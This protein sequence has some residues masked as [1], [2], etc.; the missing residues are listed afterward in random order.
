MTRAVFAG[1]AATF[2]A[3]QAVR[4]TDIFGVQPAALDQPRINAYITRTPGGAP[5]AADLGGGFE[6]F[7]IQ[8]FFDTGASGIL[9]SNNTADLLGIQRSTFNGQDVVFSDVG[10]A[11]TDDFNVSELL[12]ISLARFHPDADVDNP[13][14][15]AEYNQTFGQV[16]TQIGPIGV[17]PDPVLGDLDVFG[18]PLM[19]GKVVVMDPKPV[20]TF[21]DTMRTYV[22]NPGTP[23]NSAAA[24][25]DPGIPDMSYAANA[26]NRN[27][28]FSKADFSP[29]T[30]VS[31][32][33]ANGPT[34]TGNPF[35]GPDPTPGHT[36]GPSDPDPVTIGFGG[37][38]TTGSFLLDTGAAASMIS[39][40]KASQLGV[41]YDPSAGMGS[42]DPTLIYNGSPISNQFDLTIGGIGG[43]IKVAGFF[44]D[45]MVLPTVE[46]ESDS[47]LNLNFVGAPVLVADITVAEP[48]GTGSLTLDGIFGMNFLVASAYVTEAEPFP[49][50]DALTPSAFDWAVYDD[51]GSTLGVRIADG[52]TVS[53]LTWVGWA[54]NTW[55]IGNTASWGFL[56]TYQDGNA[57]A[58]TDLIY[59]N[60]SDTI[61]IAQ[62]VAPSNVVFENNTEEQDGVHYTLQGAGIVGTTG[63]SK[64]GNGIVTFE[65]QN[66]YT[67]LT[68]IQNGTLELRAR[69]NIGPVLVHDPA[70]LDMYTSQQFQ[71]L[72]VSG[73][74]KLMSGGDKVLV[75]GGLEFTDNGQLDLADNRLIID[76]NIT[77]LAQVRH[78]LQAG[79]A[80]GAWSGPGLV[81][82]S[83][84]TSPSLDSI[85]YALA[86]VLGIT[87]FGGEPVT[88]DSIVAR[89]TYAGDVN[90]DGQIDITDLG[91][92][93]T[94]WQT[95]SAYWYLGD[96]NFDGFVD[97]TDLGLLATNW[98]QGVGNPLGPSLDEALAAVGLPSVA[99]P[100][101]GAAVAAGGTLL[102]LARRRRST[103]RVRRA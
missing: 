14:N 89:L 13:D 63:V 93:A 2:L 48:D 55:D 1:F 37:A 71:S 3:A 62:P 50:I 58:F 79:Y 8:A 7:N 90:L 66:S 98:Q 59:D 5:L 38:S 52:S 35:I 15:L 94:N 88:G 51:P 60:S 32:T 67:G 65:N 21:L 80:N 20:N 9:L 96:F 46:G 95:G 70:R 16:R 61:N 68:D 84:A 30:I 40:A 26:N 47:S 97:I 87:S 29:Y 23:Y 92:L 31:P 43:T 34:L 44:L 6:T 69:Q 78:M 85:G 28:R 53:A 99:I 74:A 75:L 17:E 82:S 41:T 22:Y 45:T 12:Y 102:L 72:G 10:V 100:E 76:R 91:A 77:S 101:P 103:R 39:S 18:A 73:Q 49:I 4:A 83:A 81:S 36:P 27:I 86:G 11:G 25:S 56:Q 24:D 57:V 64:T 33:G 54:G 42:D 19:V